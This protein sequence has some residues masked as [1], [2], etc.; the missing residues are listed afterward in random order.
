MLHE[1]DFE[2]DSEGLSSTIGLPINAYLRMIDVLQEASASPMAKTHRDVGSTK[3]CFEP[4]ASQICCRRSDTR[5][6]L[7]GTFPVASMLSSTSFSK[8]LEVRQN[9]HQ[10]HDRRRSPSILETR[11]NIHASHENLLIAQFDR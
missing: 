9:L 4:Q 11:R 3:T 2:W 10:R 7:Y 1:A 5:G 6:F 8:A